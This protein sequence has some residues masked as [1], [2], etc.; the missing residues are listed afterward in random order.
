MWYNQGD[1][2]DGITVL[3][4]SDLAK[5]RSCFVIFKKPDFQ[6]DSE[7]EE[8]EQDLSMKLL[9]ATEYLQTFYKEESPSEEFPDLVEVD[10][11]QSTWPCDLWRAAPREI[12]QEADNV[13]L[14]LSQWRHFR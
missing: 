9:S 10:A 14:L 8:P 7:R 6:E 4:I 12:V 2:N 11:L 3:D 5:I 1:N 13:L